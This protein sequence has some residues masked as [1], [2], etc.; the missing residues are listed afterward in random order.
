[1]PATE[2]EMRSV[3]LYLPAEEHKK[4]RRVAADN[5]TNMALMARKIVIDYLAAHGPKGSSK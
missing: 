3:R 2:Q 1:M 5:E 4:L